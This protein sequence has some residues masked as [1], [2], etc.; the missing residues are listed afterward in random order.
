[1]I[2]CDILP[3]WR[4]CV[5]ISVSLWCIY[6]HMYSYLSIY[7]S[8]YLCQS[9]YIYPSDILFICLILSIYLSIYRFLYV[10]I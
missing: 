6:V 4:G 9:V 7:L 8:I 2:L 3:E 5:N 10:F 1:M